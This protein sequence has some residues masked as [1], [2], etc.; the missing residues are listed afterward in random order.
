M[1]IERDMTIND[2]I[3]II[4]RRLFYVIGTFILVFLAVLAIAIKLPPV[5][6]SKATILIESQQ[7]QSEV[8]KEKYAIDKFETLKQVVLS[9]E[10]LY[11]IAQKYKMYGLAKKPDIPFEGIVAVTRANVAVDLLT[12]SSQEWGDKSGIAVQVAFNHYEAK[13]AFNVANEL[14]KLFLLENDKANKERV[15]N[16]AEFYTKEADKQKAVLEKIELDVSSY[17]KIHA[18][19]LPENKAMLVASLTRL[20]TDLAATVRDSASAQSEIRSLEVSLESAKAGIGLNP[21]QQQATNAIELD[22]LK[23]DLARVSGLYSENHPSVQVLRQ[24]IRALED[25]MP[26]KIVTAQSIMVGKV[27]AQIDT[28]NARIIS[29]ANE[30]RD[31][32]ETIASTEKR[33]MATAQTEGELSALLREYENTKAAYTDIKAKLVNSKLAKNIEMENKGERFVVSEAP[34]VPEKPIKPNRMLIIM[35]GFFGAIGMGVGLAVLMDAFDKRV[36]GVA[37]LSTIMG[38]QPIAVIPYIKTEAEIKHQKNLIVK[39]VAITSLI[40]F[41][42]LFIVNMF[43]MPLDMLASV[44]AARF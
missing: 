30:A 9:K 4:K 25:A 38:L 39:T 31:I 22:K 5:Y 23:S 26:A 20:E 19:S 32:R 13:D 34:L 11:K 18:D 2:Y 8:G 33:I 37:V 41:F 29:L 1:A 7:V 28:A 21:G 3:N 43:V 35:V 10:N 15:Q 17:K 12:A 40:I 44:I 42:V 24:R 14:V 27:Q 6:Q 36:N 16:T